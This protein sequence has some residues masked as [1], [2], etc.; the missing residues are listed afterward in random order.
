MKRDDIYV[1]G[2]WIPSAGNG[3]I[4]ITNPATGEIIGSVPDGTSADVDA[5]VSAAKTAFLAWSAAPV[6]RRV[7]LLKAI[8]SGLEARRDEV[9]DMIVAEV[10][11][12]KA[13]A[14]I[15]QFGIVVHTFTDAAN[16]VTA[17]LEEETI[18]NSIVRKEAVGVIGAITPWNFPL[19]QIALKVA[20]ALAAGCT[21]VLKPSEVA[22]LSPY[23]LAEVIDAAGFPPGVFNLVSGTGPQVGEAIA[24]H[25][26]V[27][28]VSF[29]GS[30][31]AGRRVAEVAAATAKKV[32]LELGG[33]SAVIL[34]DD[35][36]L[37]AAVPAAMA[38]CYA[39]GGQVCAALTRMIVPRSRLSEVEELAIT[40]ANGFIAG[41]P[42]ASTTTLGPVISEAQRK[43]VF[44]LIESGIDAGAKLLI[45][46]ARPPTGQETGFF[47][48]PTVFSEVT[49]NARIAQEEVFGPVMVIIP[50]A[51]DDE[52]VAVANGTRY[53]L[54]GAVWSADVARAERVAAQLNAST[55]YINGGKF[56]PS[57]PFGGT[58]GSGYGRERGRYGVEEYLRTKAYQY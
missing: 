24:A 42:H 17:L 57:A 26:D 23:L 1:N 41:D 10:G 52:A 43:R 3:S 38:N 30:D 8:V 5:A 4:D 16:E 58:K 45:G 2:Q 34:L 51:D 14:A 48:T 47:V 40:A 19:Y 28:M 54:N 20:P 25:P 13:A 49:P 32:A 55:V 12:P 22:G 9:L 39:N 36:D 35:A 27:D 56:N 53:G 50:V 44:G 18:G 15:T 33:K 29:T 11:T 37:A 7:E 6:A 21:V 46:G 31:R